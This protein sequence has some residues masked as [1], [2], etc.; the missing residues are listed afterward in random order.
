MTQKVNN[1]LNVDGH[2][3][4]MPLSDLLAHV[5]HTEWT[6]HS[7]AGA[8]L[9]HDVLDGM[10]TLLCPL[11]LELASMSEYGE[12]IDS[13]LEHLTMYLSMI[14]IENSFAVPVPCQ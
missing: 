2:A 10:R 11:L 6:L 14:S 5:R 3:N 7:F 12:S 8:R 1:S 4:T 9:G 13:V